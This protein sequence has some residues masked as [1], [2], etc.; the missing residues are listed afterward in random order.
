MFCNYIAEK[1]KMCNTPLRK[2]IYQNDS[3]TMACGLQLRSMSGNRHG[4]LRNKRSFILLTDK[5]TLFRLL[6]ATFEFIFFF[7]WNFRSFHD[8]QENIALCFTQKK[9]WVIKIWNW[10]T[11]TMSLHLDEVNVQSRNSFYR[12]VNFFGPS[13]NNPK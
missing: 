2:I 9:R 3:F 4:N 7:W 10:A 11:Q 12:K 1:N 13:H 8:T 6:H 5:I